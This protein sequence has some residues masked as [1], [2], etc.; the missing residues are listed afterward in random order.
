MANLKYY[1]S[2]TSQWETLVI[3]KQGPTGPTGATGPAGSGAILQVVSFET[4][5]KLAGT[6][7]GS[8]NPTSTEGTF[9][10]SASFTPNFANSKILI[11]SSN[12]TMGEITNTGDE[13]Y[14][15]AYYDTT[16][17]A[18]AVTGG[19]YAHFA[20]SLSFGLASFNHVFPSWGTTTKTINI[21]V[22]STATSVNMYANQNYHYNGFL[23]AARPTSFTLMEIAQ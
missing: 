13:F 17:A 6:L 2:T 8:T 14:M 7:G 22:G 3:G 5:T 4:T 10:T 15:A 23:D 9:L 18:I 19:S 16:R 1:N 20:G 12:V 21:R 11:Q